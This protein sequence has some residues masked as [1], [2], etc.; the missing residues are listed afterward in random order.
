MLAGLY[1]LTYP[2]QAG[3]DLSENA[4]RHAGF[5]IPD[6]RDPLDDL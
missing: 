1:S 3:T 2:D 4:L 6:W 5:Q